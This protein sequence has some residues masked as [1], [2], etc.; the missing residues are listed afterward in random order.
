VP[1]EKNVA[2]MM[3]FGG[4]DPQRQR[5]CILNFLRIK[6]LIENVIEVQLLPGEPE[7]KIN[8]KVKHARTEVG[9]IPDEA[10]RTLL[11]ADILIGLITEVN[12]NVIYELAVRNLL[13]G[14]LISKRQGINLRL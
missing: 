5:R 10:L 7:S 2:V 4:T 1:I 6:Y 8:Y 13:K 12:V 3:P 9:S 14:T 11:N